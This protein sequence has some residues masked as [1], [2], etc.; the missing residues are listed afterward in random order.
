MIKVAVLKGKCINCRY[1]FKEYDGEDEVIGGRNVTFPCIFEYCSK[2]YEKKFEKGGE[3]CKGYK[4]FKMA[5]YKI[6]I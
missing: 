3:D 5:H 4:E 1:G 2:G 6:K